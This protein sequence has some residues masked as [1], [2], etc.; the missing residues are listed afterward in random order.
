MLDI[1]ITHYRETMMDIRKID[2]LWCDDITFCPEKCGW[3][4]CPRNKK[5]IR[6]KTVPHS[7]SVEIPN[8]C[9]KQQ[10]KT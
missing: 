6:D 2:G 1:I 7:F 10:I 4:S 3:K 9:P 8:D 5:N